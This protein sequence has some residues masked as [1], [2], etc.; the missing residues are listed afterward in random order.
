MTK[1]KEHESPAEPAGG[2]FRTC[3]AR[4]QAEVVEAQ[5]LRYRV[6]AGEL[7]AELPSR[8][9]ELDSDD[10]DAHCDHLLIRDGRTNTVVGTYR[11]L[12]A[13]HAKPLGGLY[14]ERIFDLRRIAGL[15]RLVELGRACV[16]PSYRSGAVISLLWSGLTSYLHE[17]GHEYVIG[18]ASIPVAGRP[19]VAASICARLL[20]DHLGPI[21]RRVFPRTAFPLDFD[22]YLDVPL[23]PLLHGYLRLGAY[24]CGDPAWDA[25]FGT[26]DLLLLL[27]MANARRTS[28]GFDPSARRALTAA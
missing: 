23:P 27:P 18:C 7:G 10:F 14:S 12:S 28:C 16:H 4:S 8:D 5:R 19:H 17:R 22:P 11:I 2:R 1:D 25:S 20:R 13:E 15:P 9:A 3:L 21:E 24:V 6:F 26:A